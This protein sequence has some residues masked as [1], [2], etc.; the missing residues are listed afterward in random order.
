MPFKRPDGSLVGVAA[1]DIK[2]T[3]AFVESVTTPRWSQKMSSFIVGV[4]G[5]K[6]WAISSQEKTPS[7]G[8]KPA[9]Q[10]LIQSPEIEEAYSH[11][12]NKKSGYLDMPYKGVDSLWAY[13]A[14]IAD[15]FFVIVVPKS[16]VMTLP[17]EVGQMFLEYSKNQTAITGVAV[18]L[19]LFLVGIVAL[20]TS[21]P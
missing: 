11:I 3:H 14:M 21:Y 7:P 10:I 1:V 4:K 18:V 2:I 13:A 17:E 6:I 15:K 5:G 8:S 19:A 16:V 20:F 12:K 9:G